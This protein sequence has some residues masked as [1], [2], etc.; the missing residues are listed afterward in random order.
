MLSA[1]SMPALTPRQMAT[2]RA[3]CDTFAPA[4]EVDPANDPHGL[5]RRAASDCGVAERVLHTLL[6]ATRRDQF[7]QIRLVLDL[8]DQPAVNGIYGGVWQSFVSMDRPQR[9]QTLLNWAESRFNLRRKAFMAL[10]RII[11]LHFYASPDGQSPS[12]NWPAIGYSGPQPKNTNFPKPIRPLTFTEDAELS[13]DVV[14]V[15]SGAGGGLIAGELTAAGLDVVVLE[16]ANYYAEPDFDGYELQSQQRMFENGGFLVTE[17]LSM[18]IL[19]GATL[20]GGTTINWAACLRP[21]EN[22]LQEWESEYGV[23]G[24][25]GPEFQQ[26][27]EAVAERIHVTEAESPVSGRYAT[28]IRGAEKL[29]YPVKVIARNVDGCKDCGFCGFGCREGA[30]RSVLRTY[31]QDA[32]DRGA[33]IAT[34]VYVD[35]VLIQNGRAVGVVGTARRADGAAVKVTVR[36]RAVVAAAGSIHTPALLLRSGLT[37]AHIGRNLHLHPATGVFG[38]YADLTESWAGVMLSHYVPQFNNLD[39]RGYGVTLESAPGHPGLAAIALPWMNGYQHK[40]LMEQY[41]RLSNILIITR[42]RDGGRVT[43]GRD[44][45]P[46]VHYSLSAHDR[47]HILR[48]VVESARIHAASGAQMIIGPNHRAGVYEGGD[49]E[50]YVERLQAAGMPDNQCMLGSAHQMSSCRMGGNPARGAVDPG[51]ESFEVRGLFVGDASALP[52]ASG[53]NPMWTIMG[54]AYMV[55]AKIKSQLA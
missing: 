43:I 41:Y 29:G 2:L 15:G 17:N 6:T 48:G 3:V 49:I 39:G 11:L 52:T 30:K 54:V 4:F 12:V 28:L 14:I 8:L 25:T 1:N 50:E 42:D 47:A 40:Q 27:L 32:C 10:K 22:V 55:A 35:R 31:L 45:R 23:T 16:K 46:R 53:V 33:R 5:Y 9:T 7:D 26:A 51:G 13:T 44:G 18:I 36:A 19:A 38:I 20:G 21:P 24:Y 37:N 34:G